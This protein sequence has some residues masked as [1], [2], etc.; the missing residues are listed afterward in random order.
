MNNNYFE[1]FLIHLNILYNL[2][3]SEKAAKTQN[4]IQLMVNLTK[5][6]YYRQDEI[7]TVNDELNYIKALLEITL[8]RFGKR[9]T[10]IQNVSEIC[11]HQYIP[12]FLIN[13]FIENVLVNGFEEKEGEW[14][15]QLNIDQVKDTLF[16]NIEDNGV[17][18]TINEV[19]SSLELKDK[20]HK[21]IR[22][23]INIVDSYYKGS[24]QIEIKCSPDKG[25]KINISIPL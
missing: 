5:Y 25:N 17:D 24:E 1:E 22:T 4:M 11:L 21:V 15:L 7:V 18:Y 12:H 16:I 3:T 13:S 8:I 2:A 9:L 6:K 14:K 20:N 10:Y 23:I 19:F